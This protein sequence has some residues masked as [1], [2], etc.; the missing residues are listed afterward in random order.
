MVSDR[1]VTFIRKWLSRARD[2][3]D[4]FDRFFS[5][6]IALVVAAQRIR[7]PSGRLVEDDSDRKRVV[8]YFQAKKL[9]IRRAVEK[10]QQEMTW[11]ARRR[12]TR[13]GTSYG[14]P[15]VD[16]GNPDLR[17]LFTRFSDHFTGRATMPEDDLVIAVAELLNKVR[18]NV[19]H[20][21]K[22]YDD[23]ED[24]DLLRNLNPLLLTVLEASE[25][26]TG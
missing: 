8:D 19:F 7:D 12:G 5:A 10:H 25:G 16:T 14:N 26:Q 20:G 11:L 23:K 18:N 2:A 22:V 24:L 15:I 3:E 17:N 13:R 6:W 1:R 9:A 4:E 21:I